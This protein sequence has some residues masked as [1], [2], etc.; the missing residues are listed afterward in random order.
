MPER[1]FNTE[2]PPSASLNYLIDPL[3]RIDLGAVEQLIDRQR[4]F[5]LHAPRQTGKT[6]VLL[7]L[8][9]HLNKK[10][11]PHLPHSGRRPTS[12]NHHLG[13]LTIEGGGS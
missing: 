13:L 12:S 8:E 7:A 9:A 6:T 1:F 10:G 11:R 3:S 2:G 5:V 4:Y